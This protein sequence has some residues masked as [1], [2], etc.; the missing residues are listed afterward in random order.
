[1]K[2][3]LTAIRAVALCVGLTLSAASFAEKQISRAI[4]KEMT[5]AQKALQGNNWAE[6]LKNL[7][8]AEAKGGTNAFDK[9]KIYEFQAYAYTK[10]GNYKAALQANEKAAGTGVYGPEDLARTNR[11]IF[12]LAGA[13]DNFPKTIEFGKKI[14]D[15]GGAT[16][17]DYAIMGQ[18]YFRMKDCRSA[19][20]YM[21]RA[22]NASRKSGA[23]PKEQF[24]Q[25]KLQC[26]FDSGDTPATMTALEDLVRL[27]N[28]KEYW[29]QLIRF[30]RQ[31]EKD[32]H[33]LR[34]LYRIM[35]NT[36]AMTD[37]QDYVEMAQLLLDVALPGEAQSVLE[38]AFAANLVTPD[39][40]ERTNRILT[41]AKGRADADRKGLKQFE[42][43]V[44]K[45][46]TGEA[47]VKLGE[48]YYGFGDYANAV[49][50]IT[51]GLAKGGVKA[52]D[53]ANAYLGLA[54]EA[55]KNTA[56]AKKAFNALKAVPGIN[57]KMAKLWDLYA[58]KRL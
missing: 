56:E 30:Q 34:M 44:A 2:F 9:T 29:N 5:A 43:D 27:T 46:K 45:A 32:D 48:V 42:A 11:M 49:A 55:A 3:E 53:E 24:F 25:I 17:D 38:A 35:L 47:S 15:S 28:K 23:A 8:A 14:V 21:D 39:K 51:R 33:N 1:M 36:G 7:D 18:T 10:Q 6:A 57:P 4:A 19:N 31:D 13:T 26:A 22:I 41:A 16:L 58:D 50:A 54:N 52:L 37:G 12:R 40:K 20:T